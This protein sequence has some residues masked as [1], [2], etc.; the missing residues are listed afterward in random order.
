[1]NCS[2]V[3]VALSKPVGFSER[4]VPWPGNA[5]LPWE[6]GLNVPGHDPIQEGIKV[7]E[8]EAGG[9][10]VVVFFQ[11]AGEEVIPLDAQPCSSNRAK[12]SQ[13]NPNATGD[14]KLCEHN[15]I[16]C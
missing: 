15:Q 5:I 1:M 4:E 2:I 11:W 8:D 10:V 7:H 6:H 14:S 12:Y 3:C 16:R 9:E 13:P